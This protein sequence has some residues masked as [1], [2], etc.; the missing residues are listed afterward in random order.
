MMMMKNMKFTR[1]FGNDDD[2]E[3]EELTM[4]SVIMIMKNTSYSRWFGD[5][6]DEEQELLTMV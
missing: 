2:E 3:H 4:V 5:N 1:W 6:D